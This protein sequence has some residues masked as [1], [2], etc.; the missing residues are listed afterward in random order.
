MEDERY[1]VGRC[2]V[3][4][5]HGAGQD[6]PASKQVAILPHLGIVMSTSYVVVITRDLFELPTGVS[7]T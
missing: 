3:W 6:A 5:S 7:C 1:K 4:L 2:N